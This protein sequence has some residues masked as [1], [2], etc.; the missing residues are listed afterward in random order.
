M[1]VFAVP[2]VG[3]LSISLSVEDEDTCI[4]QAN[5]S[6]DDLSLTLTRTAEWGK[7]PRNDLAGLLRKLCKGVFITRNLVDAFGRRQQ[8][9]KR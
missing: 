5:A 9:Q 7:R 3:V 2:G 4:A 8:S 6:I 1:I